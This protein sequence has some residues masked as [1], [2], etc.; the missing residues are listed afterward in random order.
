METEY[1]TEQI[2]GLTGY[3]R[4]AVLFWVKHKDPV[5]KLPARRIGR[6]W[7]IRKID[8]DS[9]LQRTGRKKKIPAK[10]RKRRS[11]K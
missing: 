11:K 3:T 1:T 2:E 10:L 7:V 8:L 5:K 4:T 9:F 6:T